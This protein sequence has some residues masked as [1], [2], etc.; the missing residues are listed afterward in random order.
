MGD[1]ADQRIKKALKFISTNLDHK[2]TLPDVCQ[3]VNLSSSRFCELFKKETGNTLG[4]FIV[5]EKIKKA[6]WLL[7][8]NSLPIKQISF[9]LGYRYVCNFDRD[10]KRLKG[11]PPQEYRNQ[12]QCHKEFHI[13]RIK[14]VVFLH[15][16]KFENI[17]VKFAYR[18]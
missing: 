10:F 1:G 6:C 11:I 17:L 18:K 14:R 2:I 5:E 8:N 13:K 12:H 3:V 9:D 4:K 15:I 7:E 16:V